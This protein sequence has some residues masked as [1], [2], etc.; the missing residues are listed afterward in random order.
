MPFEVRKLPVR[1]LGVPLISSWLIHKDCKILV[2]RVK[3][4]IGDWRNKTLSFVARLQ[5]IISVLSS[6]HVYWSSVFILP[7]S[8]TVRS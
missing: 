7:E 3:N 1:Y 5:L 2:E 4:R 8:I 6:M